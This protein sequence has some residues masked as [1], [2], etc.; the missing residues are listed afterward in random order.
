MKST[1]QDLLKRDIA[2]QEALEKARV[3]LKKFT[4]EKNNEILNCTNQVLAR[5][6][7][8]IFNCNQWR[9]IGNAEMVRLFEK[10]NSSNCGF[11]K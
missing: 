1:H 8:T 7:S 2:N 9:Y 11:R 4:D 3:Q 10:G 6:D 5:V